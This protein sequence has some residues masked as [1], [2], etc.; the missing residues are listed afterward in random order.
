MLRVQHGFYALMSVQNLEILYYKLPFIIFLLGSR[1]KTIE[2]F[3][4]FGK[5]EIFDRR[6]KVSY[7][8]Y[9]AQV[10]KP[11]QMCR[12]VQI[13]VP[14]PFVRPSKVQPFNIIGLQ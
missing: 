12:K 13:K 1:R 6:F 2:C 3:I 11:A 4:I 14:R 10:Y 8:A 7:Q 9:Y 5:Y